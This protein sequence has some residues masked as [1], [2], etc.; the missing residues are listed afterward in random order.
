MA[1]I[2]FNPNFGPDSRIPNNPFYS[3]LESVFNTP[4]GPLIF[5]AGISVNYATGVVSVDPTP[6]A[7]LGT[8]TS[9]TAG[10]GLITSAGDRLAKGLVTRADREAN[11]VATKVITVIISDL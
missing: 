3:P 7:S 4:T 11:A 6:P 10:V 1:A 2:D 8:V 5:G 9:V